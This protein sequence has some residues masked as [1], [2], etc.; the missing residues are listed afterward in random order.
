MS[1]I[2][3][4]SNKHRLSLTILRILG[5]EKILSEHILKEVISCV[6]EKISD[7]MT[8]KRI[9]LSDNNTTKNLFVK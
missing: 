2:D 3:A 1:N 9:E 8:S 6:S 7:F 5:L 4:A